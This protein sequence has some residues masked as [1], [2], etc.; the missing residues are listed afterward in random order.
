MMAAAENV[1][2]EM[3]WQDLSATIELEQRLHP[4]DAWS[5][6]SWWAELALRPRRDYLVV[7][8]VGAA[9]GEHLL[10]YAG[11]DL[12][13][14]HADVMTIAVAPQARGQGYAHRLLH[15][16]HQR[17]AASGARQM[18]LEV[19]A[20]NAAA[21]A[22]YDRHGYA[23]VRRRPAYYRT[24]TGSVDAIVLSVALPAR[25]AHPSPTQGHLSTRSR[26]G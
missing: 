5:P 26:R 16:L 10:G 8:R 3:R 23:Q 13:G 11:S 22:L 18:L 12:A 17:A 19:R 6:A 20:D 9:P 24:G 21:R 25:P 1:V 15:D 7:Q 14:A 2:R 4:D